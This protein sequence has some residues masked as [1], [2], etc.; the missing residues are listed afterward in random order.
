LNKKTKS[1]VETNQ[2]KRNACTYIYNA[3]EEVEM[4]FSCIKLK[5]RKENLVYVNG[6]HVIV[7]VSI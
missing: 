4:K 7:T 1:K 2:S 6:G 5:R 3:Q